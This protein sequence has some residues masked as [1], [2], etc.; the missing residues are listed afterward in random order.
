MSRMVVARN[1]VSALAFAAI[2]FGTAAASA[3]PESA[4]QFLSGSGSDAV[5]EIEAA[6]ARA[7][8]QEFLSESCDTHFC[9]ALFKKVPAG[10]RLEVKSVSCTFVTTP[11][12]ARILR[13]ALVA[14]NKNGVGVGGTG[15]VPVFLGSAVGE[16]NSV[17]NHE[18]FMFVKAGG[19]IE[20]IAATFG[21]ATAVDLN[22]GIAGDMVSLN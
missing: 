8:Y 9:T 6:G 14:L 16:G 19:R 13:A 1:L 15:L 20:A 2:V 3:A 10:K 11:T 17:A 22:C 12:T 7:P 18:V 21:T 4:G 5:D